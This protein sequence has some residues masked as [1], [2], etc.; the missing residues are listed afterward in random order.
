MQRKISGQRT[1]ENGDEIDDE[2][3]HSFLNWF[4]KALFKM[5]LSNEYYTI[6]NYFKHINFH[7]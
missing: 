5:L 1:S 6:W 4:G 2:M 7:L 3:F